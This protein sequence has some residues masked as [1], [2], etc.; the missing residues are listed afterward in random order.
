M[1]DRDRALAR[2]FV[3][4]A[5]TLIDDF[6]IVEFLHELCTDVVQLVGAET[7]GVML[8]DSRGGLRLLAS[9]EE[10]MRVLEVFELQ[11]KQGP[12]LD[13][14]R[15]HQTVAAT[16]AEGERLWPNF[17]AYAAEL[18]FRHMCAVPLQLRDVT[19]GA[20]NLFRAPD[21]HFAEAD[22]EIAQAMAKV[23]VTGLLQ[24]RTIGEGNAISAQ[25]RTALQS[26]I[27]IEQAKGVLAE[28]LNV[29]V[30]DAFVYLRDHARNSNRKLTELARDVA[31]KRVD[32]SAFTAPRAPRAVP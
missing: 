10:R 11:S 18:G 32:A 28:Y 7:A 4:L 30:D 26:R 20:L 27:A 16:V 23:A 5:D 6:D 15:T 12:C 17:A 29:S 22:L 1:Q 31:N 14:Y 8:A 21:E 19:I 9:S 25:L 3:R 24:R 2:V 13:A